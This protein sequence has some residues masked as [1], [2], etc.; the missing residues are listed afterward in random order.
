MATVV[1]ILNMVMHY[2]IC[3]KS[4]RIPVPA[5]RP[6]PL[7]QQATYFEVDGADVVQADGGA[8]VVDKGIWDNILYQYARVKPF[9]RDDCI[10]LF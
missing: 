9:F 2:L 3:V 1:F 6:C 5:L 4:P 10:H 8:E 7:F